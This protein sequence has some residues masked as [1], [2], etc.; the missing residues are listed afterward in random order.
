M[1]PVEGQ[2]GKEDKRSPQAVVPMTLVNLYLH[3]LL[4]LADFYRLNPL[5]GRL[6]LIDGAVL[7][8]G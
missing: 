8:K 1:Q 4:F 2:S 6:Y 5:V 3:I 7:G